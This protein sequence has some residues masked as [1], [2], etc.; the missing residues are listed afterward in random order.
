M[1]IGFTGTQNG[2]TDWQKD[3]FLL[4]IDKLSISA[5]SH[6]DCIGADAQANEI[7]KVYGVNFF[8]IWPS[9][10]A[11]KRANVWRLEQ[12]YHK[13]PYEDRIIHVQVFPTMAAL[14]RNKKIV[15]QC[16]VLIACPKEHQ[17]T[18]RSGT[19]ATIRYA[20][21]I[22]KDVMIIP[23]LEREYES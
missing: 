7:A 9:T 6:G 10:I 23:P 1:L 22:K 11:H 13:I 16:A 3:Q 21:K 12:G 19:W 18:V 8:D 4:T 20:W 2:M 15:D 14:E 17:H 5:L